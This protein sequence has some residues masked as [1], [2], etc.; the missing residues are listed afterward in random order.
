MNTLNFNTI[1]RYY[2]FRANGIIYMIANYNEARL[3]TTLAQR[4]ATYQRP[5]TII[6]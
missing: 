5:V 4:L 6:I 2:E 3:Y 1:T